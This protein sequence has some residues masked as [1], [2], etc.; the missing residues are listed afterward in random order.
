[1]LQLFSKAGVKTHC[2]AEAPRHF[3]TCA[4]RMLYLRLRNGAV[5][6]HR[7]NEGM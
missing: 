7:V 6:S 5:D 1:M 4:G 3:G 2:V